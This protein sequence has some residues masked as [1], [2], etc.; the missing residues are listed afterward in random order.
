MHNGGW[1]RSREQGNATNTR[2]D[3]Q[4]LASASPALGLEPNG[5]G[6]MSAATDKVPPCSFNNSRPVAFPNPA[7]TSMP[8]YAVMC[9]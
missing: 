2:F 6:L 7:K 9:S 1:S 8:L 4:T 3:L 5:P